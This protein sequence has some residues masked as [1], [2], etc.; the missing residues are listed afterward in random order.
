MV[1]PT[2][3]NKERYR[4][5]LKAIVGPY[6]PHAAI[7]QTL[8]I[9]PIS[10]LG[11]GAARIDVK[12]LFEGQP[13]PGAVMFAEHRDGARLDREGLTTA[14]DG[15]TTFSLAQPGRWLIRTVHMRKCATDCGPA[16]WESHWAALTFDVPGPEKR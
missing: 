12:L 11:I 9:V 8:E 1:D 5:Y 15:T 16:E 10:P 7:G 14:E 13:L 6:A 4:R 2:R 3:P